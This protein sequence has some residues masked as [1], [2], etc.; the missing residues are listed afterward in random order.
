LATTYNIDAD[1]I[2]V[3]GHSMG[4]GAVNNLIN[5]RPTQI[6]A[7]A[8]LCGFRQLTTS[9]DDTPPTLVVAAELDPLAKPERVE[10]GAQK[11]IDEG[12]PVE[13]KLVENYGHTLV[14]GDIMHE[15]IEW[16]LTAHAGLTANGR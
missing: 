12:L 13:Y 3:V 10:P 11:A 14:V 16:L 2:Y 8:A 5:S 6:A 4:G 7:A 9:K 1:R 15:T